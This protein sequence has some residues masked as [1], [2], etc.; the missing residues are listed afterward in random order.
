MDEWAG[1]ENRDYDSSLSDAHLSWHCAEG[2]LRS[3][4]TYMVVFFK[5]NFAISFALTR[6]WQYDFRVSGSWSQSIFC[7][8]GFDDGSSINQ[9]PQIVFKDHAF[10]NNI[11]R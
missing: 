5:Q 9:Q 2:D 1:E 8:V 4:L 6:R 10:Y 7:N 3:G 11:Q